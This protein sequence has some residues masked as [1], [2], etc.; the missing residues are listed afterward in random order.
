M[1][2]GLLLLD[3]FLD[4][5][6]IFCISA[7]LDRFYQAIWIGHGHGLGLL[8]LDHFFFT[9]GPFSFIWECLLALLL[10]QHWVISESVTTAMDSQ[11]DYF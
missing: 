3:L 8:F 9:Y 6:C 5:P 2:F 10:F 1:N 7:G 4:F 11:F